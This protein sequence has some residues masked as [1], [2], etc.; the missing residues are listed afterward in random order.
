MNV[1]LEETPS[2]EVLDR[3]YD[4][5]F[6]SGVLVAVH[7]SKWSMSAQLDEEDL[8]IEKVPEIIRLG[9]KMLIKPVVFNQFSQL[10][11]R[12]RNYLKRCSRPFPI[13]QAHFVPIN[14]LKEVRTQ[15]DVYKHDYEILTESFYEKY[16]DYKNEVLESFPE[17]AD[18]LEPYYPTLNVIKTK[19]GF[20]YTE[21]RISMPQEFEEVDLHVMLAEEEK[22]QELTEI[23]QQRYQ[24]Q[25]RKQLK[26]VTDFVQ[27]SIKDLRDGINGVCTVIVN[28]INK[29]EIVSET[30][31]NTLLKEIQNFEKLNV[32]DD[33]AL[34]DQLITV[35]ELL[36]QG[37][38]YKDKE[39]DTDRNVLKE[40][41]TSVMSVAQSTSDISTLTGEY[42]RALEV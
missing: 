3:Y 23:H 32:W 31:K 20:D 6:S 15:L 25:V 38:D 7:V 8:K 4:K 13:S 17:Y 10:E 12:A 16:L 1:E 24:E 40:Y 26:D 35:R 21:F 39:N 2:S 33:K 30:N 5:L 9:K 18:V 34:A 29:G 14:I 28:K 19:F 22:V 42:F 27:D 11:Q 36:K 37:H 41:L